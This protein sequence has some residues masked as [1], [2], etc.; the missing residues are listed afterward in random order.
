MVAFK[1]LEL[2]IT[3]LKT[4]DKE[5]SNIKAVHIKI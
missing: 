4:A 1:N 2:Q 3:T 5:I